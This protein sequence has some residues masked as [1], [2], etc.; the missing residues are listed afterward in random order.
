MHAYMYVHKYLFN[1]YILY[2]HTHTALAY[3]AHELLR[4]NIQG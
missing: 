4:L 2:L 1:T 3:P